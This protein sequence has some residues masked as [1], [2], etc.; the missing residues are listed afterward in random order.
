MTIEVNCQL[1]GEMVD[2]DPDKVENPIICPSCGEEIELSDEDLARL[3]KERDYRDIG[4]L[5]FLA[6]GQIDGEFWP[7][8]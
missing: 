2:L 7:F 3:Q 5:D 1:C 6:D 8:G 4:T